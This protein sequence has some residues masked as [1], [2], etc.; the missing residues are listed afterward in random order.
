M[1]IS[2][3]QEI[4]DITQDIMNDVVTWLK[5]QTNQLRAKPARLAPTEASAEARQGA[6]GVIGRIVHVHEG[7]ANVRCAYRDPNRTLAR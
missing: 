4:L 2:L 3:C 5:A 1:A 6:L 7:A